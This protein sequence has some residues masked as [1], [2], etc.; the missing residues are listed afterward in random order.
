M[1]H[2]ATCGPTAAI[3][4]IIGPILEALANCCQL[5]LT[6]ASNDIARFC[7]AYDFALEIEFGALDVTDAFWQM[8]KP[9]CLNRVRR[10]FRR[11]PQSGLVFGISED[12]LI[13]AIDLIWNDNFF[14]ALGPNGPI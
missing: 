4:E 10:L 2:K 5:S 9:I 3:A 6:Q 14:T 1:T 12:A 7:A 11:Y 8:S 13:K